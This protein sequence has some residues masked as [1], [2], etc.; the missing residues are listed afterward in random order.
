MGARTR[1]VHVQAEIGMGIFDDDAGYRLDARRLL[2]TVEH[3]R[4]RQ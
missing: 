1:L 2:R 3:A 4:R